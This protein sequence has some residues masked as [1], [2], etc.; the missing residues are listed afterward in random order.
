MALGKAAARKKPQKAAN[1]GN[2]FAAVGR[3]R[4][5]GVAGS[6]RPLTQVVAIF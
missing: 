5:G 2:E 6:C 4:F 1:G 3:I